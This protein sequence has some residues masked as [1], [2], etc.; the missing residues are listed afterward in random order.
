MA[1][2]I[3]T[4]STIHHET[5]DDV[6]VE[7]CTDDQVQHVSPENRLIIYRPPV[8]MT[9]KSL[10]KLNSQLP[11]GRFVFRNPRTDEWIMTEPPTESLKRKL[12]LVPWRGDAKRVLYDT[13]ATPSKV[14]PMPWH[15]TTYT[16][17]N[18]LA[19][20]YRSPFDDKEQIMEIDAFDDNS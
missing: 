1:V 19:A 4:T 11:E 8:R 15:D 18:A 3:D 10:A 5:N 9:A 13:A 14:I 16:K 7:E 6:V 2:E 12:A 17:S 20:D